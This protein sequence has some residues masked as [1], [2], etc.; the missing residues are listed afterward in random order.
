MYAPCCSTTHPGLETQTNTAAIW[1][2]RVY[3]ADKARKRKTGQV[4][5]LKQV[6]IHRE[7]EG[8]TLQHS[9]SS[10]MVAVLPV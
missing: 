2:I 7:A 8:V 10:Y 1:V 6:L 9:S 4:V 3:A 5:A